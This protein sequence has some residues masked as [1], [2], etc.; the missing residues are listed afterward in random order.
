MGAKPVKLKLNTEN[1]SAQP[2]LKPPLRRRYEQ[3]SN[4]VIMGIYYKFYFANNIFFKYFN[5]AI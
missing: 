3:Y 2:K 5:P 1:R 4:L